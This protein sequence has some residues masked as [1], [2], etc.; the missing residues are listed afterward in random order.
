M[1]TLKMLRERITAKNAWEDVADALEL[2]V[3]PKTLPQSVNDD[4]IYRAFTEGSIKSEKLRDK[5]HRHPFPD[6]GKLGIYSDFSL[7]YHLAGGLTNAIQISAKA[8]N[9]HHSMSSAARVL[10]FGCGTSRILRYLV[11]F[12]PGP[13]YYASE[14]FLENVRWGQWAFPEVTYLHQNSFPPLRHGGPPFRYHIRLFDLHSF[15]G[16]VP[17]AVAVGATPA[18][19]TRRLVDFNSSW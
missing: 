19:E 11:E 10:D 4:I 3:S 12:L 8:E 16:G 13:Q 6:I 18:P 9:H 7:E 15:G 14:V 5:L 2:G 17:S 1:V